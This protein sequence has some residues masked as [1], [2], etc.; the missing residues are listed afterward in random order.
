MAEPAVLLRLEKRNWYS[1]VPLVN[2]LESSGIE[3]EVVPSGSLI[4][5]IGGHISGKRRVIVCISFFTTQ[6]RSTSDLVGRIRTRYG[7]DVVLS[8]GGPHATGAPL[9]TLQM[10][11]DYAV[12]GEGEIVLPQMIRSLAEGDRRFAAEDR[13][14]EGIPLPNLDTFPPVSF[15]HHLY[16]PIEITRGCIFSCRYCSVPLVFDGRLRH[17][18]VE[19][20][21]SAGERLVR[22]GKRWDFR[23]ISPNSLGYGSTGRRPREGSVEKLLGALRDLGG[24]KRIFFATFPSEA[25]PDFV[26]DR[27]V[28]IVSE[29]ADNRKIS[30]GAQSGS[31]EVLRRIRRGHGVETVYRAVETILSRGLT[32]I[33]D[34]ILGLPG[35]E[36][37]DQRLT[38]AAMGSIT[39]IGG[40]ARV[41]HFIPL[42]GSELGAERPAPISPSVMSEVGRMSLKGIASGSFTEQMR[43]AREVVEWQDL[44]SSIETSNR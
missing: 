42:P 38:L 11:F 4:R 22:T 32:P 3:A 40:E 6:A 13:V 17:R 20:V 5:E 36:E 23:F 37:E 9:D 41:H 24:N 15:G 34:F 10:G 31:D 18:S 1:L 2:S 19:S 14:V 44:S 27:M 43:L 30:I 7:R 12:R 26:T 35:E 39:E 28:E 29:L 8:E 25:R 16:P 33:V 21:V